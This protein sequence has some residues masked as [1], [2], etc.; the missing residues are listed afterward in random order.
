MTERPPEPEENAISDDIAALYGRA[1]LQGTRYWDFSASREEVQGQFRHRIAR[2]H[3]E[4]AAAGSAFARPTAAP[5]TS[6]QFYSAPAPAAENTAPARNGPVLAPEPGAAASATQ[7]RKSPETP[8]GYPQPS[9]ATRWYALHSVIAPAIEPP[10]SLPLGSEQRPPI[11]AV[12]SFAGG[13]GK[14][15]VV[16]TL[17]RALSSFAENVLLAD[18]NVG[19]PLPFYYGAHASK[20]GVLRTFTPPSSPSSRS[21]SQVPV[22]LLSLQA[23]RNAGDDNEYDPLL[24]RLVRGGRGVSRI[25]VD[26]ATANWDVVNRLL[27]LRPTLLVPI[28]PDINSV[29]SLA[30][31]EAFLSDQKCFYLLNQFDPSL[32]LHLDVLAMLQQR[33]GSRLLPVVVRRSAAVSESLAEGLTVI[34]YA[35]DS[36]AAEDYRHLA[37]WLRGVAAPAALSR[38]GVRWSER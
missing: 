12:V 26:V 27:A 21:E 2:E 30:P 20:P 14:T 28:L 33:L 32:T 34:D 17:G 36:P 11:L 16:A 23:D 7:P 38:G 4:R 31:L 5:L 24:A 1:Q 29:A 18:V 25:L 10:R 19:G 22:Q 13:V 35:P 3:A 6:R 8:A 15:C 37:D 9:E